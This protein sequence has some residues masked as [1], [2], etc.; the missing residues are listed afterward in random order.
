MIIFLLVTGVLGRDVSGR[1]TGDV[2]W[3]AKESPVHVTGN[4]TVSPGA[5]LKIQPGVTVIL[6]GYF[7]IEVQGVL[8]ASGSETKSIV[9]TIEQ[10]PPKK[11]LWKGLICTGE[12]SRVVLS[13][14]TVEFAFK[15]ICWKSTPLIRFCTFRNNTYGFYCSNT[16]SAMILKSTFTDNTYGIYC[17]FSSPTIQGNTVTNNGYGIYCIFSSAPLVGQN[18]LRNNT[19]KDIFLDDS[20]G[21]NEIT[22]RNQYVWSLVRGFF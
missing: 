9:F 20:M 18:I 12:Q 16:K 6:D 5:S 17:D 21:K 1:L 3:V 19:S 13:Y 8:E 22:A 4:V 7:H 15:N 14:C 2:T 10:K 11:R